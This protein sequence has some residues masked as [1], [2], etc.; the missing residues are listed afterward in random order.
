MNGRLEGFEIKYN[1]SKFK[2]YIE[3]LNTYKENSIS[4]INKDNFFDFVS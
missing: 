3:F 4:I 1:Y 2:K